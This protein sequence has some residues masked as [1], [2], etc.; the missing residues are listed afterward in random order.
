MNSLQ[1]LC[2]KIILKSTVVDKTTDT[3]ESIDESC[4]KLNIN[5]NKENSNCEMTE[6]GDDETHNDDFQQMM[7]LNLPI[8][9]GNSRT[10]KK[11]ND[12]SCSNANVS[13][14]KNDSIKAAFELLCVK[15]NETKGVKTFTGN[16]NYKVKH[17]RRQ[18]RKLK[19]HPQV[20]DQTKITPKHVFFNDEGEISETKPSSS[21]ILNDCKDL[22]EELSLEVVKDNGKCIDDKY[23]EGN[24]MS[25]SN[26]GSDYEDNEYFPE[27][28]LLQDVEEQE[29]YAYKKCY[30]KKKIR[31][32]KA[33]LPIEIKNNEKLRKYW[34]RRFSL[35]S[36]FDLGVK[37]D[38]ESWF[39]V[40]PEKIAKNTAQRC[41]CDVIIDAFCGAGG[42][43]I[44]FALTCNKVI[45]I[46]IDP[47]KIQ[48]ARNNAE[49]Y[50]VADR[51]EFVIGDF[52]HLADK[53]KGDVV[54]LSPPWGGP[55][56][57]N[58]PDYDLEKFLQP[59]PLSEVLETARKITENVALFLPRNS[60]IFPLL[61]LS[62]EGKS[63]EIEQNFLND[64]LIALTAYYG[65]LIKTSVS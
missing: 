26:T 18:N 11:Y 33:N 51:I 28:N 49:V 22:T 41:H 15:F 63:V 6:D 54:F 57:L 23:D 37:L 45:A 61:V 64:R 44:Q 52:F 50:N 1:N 25:T 56:Y 8:S 4:G 40:T 20:S 7:S 31:K 53:L 34:G 21:N 38:E 13:Q 10:N 12:T 9:F 58:L 27:N 14:I 36:K 43:S 16:V 29:K 48:L 17:I 19:I 60:N 24:A 3:K 65:R 46:D 30:P 47:K 62:G 39:S 42:N 5:D 32:R 35:F 2:K 59:K 55:S